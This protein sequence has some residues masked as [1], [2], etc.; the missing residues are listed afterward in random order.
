MDLSVL[1]EICKR[2][3]IKTPTIG[4]LSN[5]E[6]LRE[7]IYKHRG[8]KGLRLTYIKK[9]EES[10]VLCLQDAIN[11]GNKEKSKSLLGNSEVYLDAS[12]K[13][14]GK[15]VLSIIEKNQKNIDNTKK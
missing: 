2:E 4:M 5:K 10:A 12:I 6:E 15:Q 9:L 13:F 11:K 3:N 1:K 8:T 7:Y 14:D